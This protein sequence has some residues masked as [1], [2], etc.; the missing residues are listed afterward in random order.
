MKSKRILIGVAV[1]LVAALLIS[2]GTV[3]ALHYVGRLPL[4]EKYKV[5]EENQLRIACVGD[6]VTYGFGIPDREKYNYPEVLA[7]IFGEDACVNNYGVSGRTVSMDGDRPYMN[8]EA[9]Q[10]SLDFLPDVVVL[11][12]G[13]NDAKPYNWNAEAFERDYQELLYAY[14]SL[15]SQPVIFVVL[16]TPVFEVR[17]KVAFN[18]DKDVLENEIVPRTRALAEARRYTVIDMHEVFAGHPELFS[19]GCHPNKE[20]AKLF[21]ETV[22]KALLGE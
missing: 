16:P 22:A 13:S 10:A 4:G 6:S 11:M 20:G 15:K 7:G 14:K 12:L 9:F 2:G 8:E 1:A 3:F 21:A 17:G 18:I 5:P 19:D